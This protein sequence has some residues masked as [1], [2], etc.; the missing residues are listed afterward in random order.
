MYVPQGFEMF[1]PAYVVLLLLHTIYGTVQAA[2][3]FWKKL[4]SALQ[5]MNFERS[6]AD[7]CLYFCWTSY[8]LVIFISWV[9]DLLCCGKE[10]AVKE[11]KATLFDEFDCDDVGALIEYVWLQN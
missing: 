8:G 3:Q 7:A 5:R 1:Y 6:K 2:S 9:D 4:L 10:E 11:A